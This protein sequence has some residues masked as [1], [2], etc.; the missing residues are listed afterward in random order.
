MFDP[1]NLLEYQAIAFLSNE[2]NDIYTLISE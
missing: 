2:E 1:V